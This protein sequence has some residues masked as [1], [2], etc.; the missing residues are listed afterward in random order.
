MEIDFEGCSN[1]SPLL[2]SEKKRHIKANYEK[3]VLEPL[4]DLEEKFVADLNGADIVVKIPLHAQRIFSMGN[5]GTFV[6]QRM[7]FVNSRCFSVQHDFSCEAGTSEYSLVKSTSFE[8]KQNGKE[9]ID[10]NT[11]GGLLHLS[12][13]E[14]FYLLNELNVLQINGNIPKENDQIFEFFISIFGSSFV[15]KYIIYRYFRKL[16]WVVRDGLPFG[17]DFLLYKDGI[18]FNHSCAGIR[19]V[20]LTDSIIKNISISASQRELNNCK[21]QFLIAAVDFKV[22]EE[23]VKLKDVEMA[24]VKVLFLNHWSLDKQRAIDLI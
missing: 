16:G 7:N 22:L 17:V 24:K 9:W 4:L 5:F 6:G 18:E 2:V 15:R 21:K 11:G 3:P 13:V 10:K 1:S 14:A 12:P 23:K 19:I 20:S 8:S